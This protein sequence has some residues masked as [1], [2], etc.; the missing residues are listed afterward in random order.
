MWRLLLLTLCTHNVTGGVT[1]AA[2]LVFCQPYQIFDLMPSQ[3]GSATTW[4]TQ[5]QCIIQRDFIRTQTHPY[6]IYADCY[7]ALPAPVIHFEP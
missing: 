1:P 4:P 2:P 5:A 3:L 7:N 6:V